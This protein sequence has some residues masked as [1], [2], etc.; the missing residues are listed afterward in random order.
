MKNSDV[1]LIHR[2]L[3][4]DDS[5]FS[6]LVKKYQKPVHALV[7]RKIG[8]FHIAEEITQDTFLKAYQRL[9][10]LKQPQR[11]TGWL[12]VIAANNCKMW[13]RK[14]RLQTQPLEETDRTELEKATYSEYIVE[15]KERT[16]AEAK[17]EVVKQLLATLQ[18]SDR[19]VITLHYFSDMSAADIGAFLGVS[20]NTIKSRLRRAQ[21]R[22]KQEEPMV[23]EALEHFQ[24]TPHLTE[25]IMREI[26]RMKPIAP[27]GSKPLTPLAVSA[28]T[29]IFIFLIM[30]IGSQYLA[31]FQRPYNIDAVSETTIEIIDAPIVLDT[32]AKPDL[33]NQAGRF[34][35]TGKSSASGPQLSEPVTL[36]AA[37]IEKETRLSTQQQWTQALG[38]EST[39]VSG[40]YASSTGDIYAAS[41]V[42][43]YRLTPNASAWTLIN[44][45]I[46]MSGRTQ[47]AERDGTLYLASTGEV[48]ASTDRGESWKVL[49]ERPKGDATGLVATDDGLYL[50][51]ETQVFRSTDAGEQWIPFGDKVEDMFNF[52]IA[53]IE[54]TVFIGTNQGLY[55]IQAGTWEKLPIETTNAIHSLAVSKNHLYVGT[56]PDLTQLR[57]PEGRMAYTA[58]IMGA[59]NSS[60][61]EI[62]HSTNLGNSWTEI[63]PTSDSPLMKISQGVKILAAGETLLALGI[64]TNFRS[65]DA[66]KTWTNL[67]FNFDTET[68]DMK[69]MMDSIMI[70]L[71]PA[72]TVNENTFIKAG[73]LEL[74]RSTDG[75]KS[76]HPF[77]KGIIGTIIFNLVADKNAI[78]TSTTT[79][80][81]KSIDGGDSWEP[82]RPN[83]GEF[84]LQPT[85]NGHQS[86]L[87]MFPKLSVSGDVLYV[88]AK[89]L[90]ARNRLR[91]L[92]FSADDNMLVPIQG[93]PIFANDIQTQT[94]GAESPIAPKQDITD[95]SINAEQQ[96]D[97][98]NQFELSP[99][100]FAVSGNTF[101]VEYKQRLF[102]WT[103]GDS[104]WT[105]T[106][107]IDT[108]QLS[109]NPSDSSLQI[110]VENPF[111]S[112]LQIAVSEETVYVGKRDGHLLRSPDAGN[113]W[114]DLTPN[115]PLRFEHFNEIVFGDSVVYVATDTGVLTSVDG[116]HWQAI[117]D[118]DGTHTIID[119]MAVSGTTIYGAGDKGVYQLDKR[120]RWEQISPEVP[121]TVIA[122][123]VKRNRLYIVTARRG[124]F[125]ISLE[126]ENY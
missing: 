59:A 31:R 9:A 125:H 71:A 123:V 78:Y 46:A 45:S 29:A 1:E 99:N 51:L 115:L 94:Q 77:T 26:S 11:F 23:R 24:I 86:N 44:T 106:G 126:N 76:W 105:D 18:E 2:I 103:R 120:N 119:R 114:K 92:R 83:T 37:Q 84:I 88:A 68:F 82:L 21:Q 87:L 96:T 32:Q 113:T 69:A 72:V 7:W 74:T 38:P 62:F 121:D 108:T 102:R 41:P 109:D 33:R 66:G 14:K 22:L 25:N 36:G 39:M 12:Y 5:A 101:Y 63:T 40:L 15:E 30:G 89:D 73:I 43:I 90:V 17:R 65:M 27:S 122:L 117:T 16:I 42:G 93:I 91:I 4:G 6:E 3:D 8:D 61:W 80:V 104:E 49:G 48:L 13:L 35:T 97:V 57:T 67:G 70:S 107:L 124:I 52:A 85:E 60:T 79:G 54:N 53:V 50:V 98:E 10:T 56:G 95:D 34:E 19:T 110:A 47:M 116:E 100:G 28:A 20:V 111:D 118:N 75:G 112:G 64:V 81:S 58:Q 55:R